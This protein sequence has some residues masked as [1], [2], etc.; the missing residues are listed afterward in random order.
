MTWWDSFKQFYQSFKLFL[1]KF[2]GNSFKFSLLYF[3]IL[4][5][6]SIFILFLNILKAFKDNSFDY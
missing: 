6:L 3:D 1:K 4:S 2:K 5:I